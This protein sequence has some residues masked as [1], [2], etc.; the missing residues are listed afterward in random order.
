MQVSEKSRIEDEISL[1]PKLLMVKVSLFSIF[2]HLLIQPGQR[3]K[4]DHKTFAI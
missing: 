1:E 3:L 2:S 4:W